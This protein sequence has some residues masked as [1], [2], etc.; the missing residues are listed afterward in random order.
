MGLIVD[1]V[2][3]F[4]AKYFIV[5]SVAAAAFVWIR[6]SVYRKWTLATAAI[7]GGVVALALIRGSAAL[8]NDPRPFVVQHIH[9]LFAHAADNGFPSDHST[10]AMFIAV[11]VLVYSRP[12]GIALIV[13][14]FLV[15]TAR[16]LA[17]VHH[18]LDIG[19]GFV[20]GGLTAALA[21]WAAPWIVRRIP[22]A[23]DQDSQAAKPSPAAKHASADPSAGTGATASAR[24]DHL[25]DSGS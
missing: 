6:Q 20:L 4:V 21:C 8:Y 12:W 5:L 7:S 15:G 22:W 17:H 16:V 1:S 10:L 3:V 11:C 14:A 18:P 24:H 23:P 25:A 13:N 2:I 19:A 9:P